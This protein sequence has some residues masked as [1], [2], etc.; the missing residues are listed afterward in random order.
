MTFVQTPVA[1]SRGENPFL[2]IW[3]GVLLFAL[4]VGLAFTVKS[5]VFPERYR[6]VDIASYWAAART[7]FQDGDSPYGAEAPRLARQRWMPDRVEVPPFLYTPAALLAMAPLQ[8]MTPLTAARALFGV[9]LLAT[10]VM[11]LFLVRAF[12]LGSSRR[13]AWTSALYVLL[14]P[15][16][17]ESIG[18]GQVNLPLMLLVFGVWHV[19]RSGHSTV[20]G[21]VA[22][23][24]VIF[25][26]LH[27]G[28]LLLPVLLRR[29]ATLLAASTGALVLGTGLS[30]GVF[31]F[32]A[33][34]SW[35][36]HVVR[37]SSLVSLPKG[38]PGVDMLTNLSLPSMTAR[39]LLPSRY[40]ASLDVPA[41]VSSAVPAVLCGAVLLWT[42]W[43]LWRS[44][45]MPHT[46]QRAN[47][48]V[49][50]ALAAAY[51]LSPLS[52]THH[53]VFILP[54]MLLLLRHIVFTPG[55]SLLLRGALAAAMLI[56]VPHPFLLGHADVRVLVAMATLQSLSALAIWG[57]SSAW[58]L[59]L[60]AEPSAVPREDGAPEAFLRAT[61]SQ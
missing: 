32:N 19:Y 1:A 59:H 9:N 11:M 20:A 31:P 10:G 44:S 55:R 42:A 7:A 35:L 15:P 46:P 34:G 48:E 29:R 40:R 57:A 5:V 61:P 50:L 47:A 56:L 43:A 45:R 49:C 30:A 2:P 58:V 6:D 24:S 16:L 4:F 38:L 37:A 21:G 51:E 22:A 26:K 41:W 54:T 36:E 23:A 27:L 52:W 39:F 53:L 18:A 14:F 33:W 17:Y 3:A 13:L 25:L 12:A 28:L 8:W 60:S